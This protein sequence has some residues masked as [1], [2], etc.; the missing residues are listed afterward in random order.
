MRSTGTI[1]AGFT[2]LLVATATAQRPPDVG[3]RMVEQPIKRALSPRKAAFVRPGGRV[4]PGRVVWHGDFKAAVAAAAKSKRP[5]MLF[6]LLGR[7]DDEFC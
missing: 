7:L 2:A 6:Q 4:A 3:K 1:T 5:V